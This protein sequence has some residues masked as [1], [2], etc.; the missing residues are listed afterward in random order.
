MVEAL[1]APSAWQLTRSYFL[2]ELGAR[3]LSVPIEMEVPDPRPDRFFT[4]EQLNTRTVWRFADSI[5]LQ[6]RVYDPDGKRCEHVAS[7]CKGLW[8]VMPNELLV[9]DVEHAGGPVR[10][11]D[12]NV[13]SLERYLV[14]AWV[15]VMNAPA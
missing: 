9:Q 10:Q 2:A 15:T 1:V 3:S 12:P 8:L 4:L 13:P 6:L 7:L 5:L 14:T 11:K